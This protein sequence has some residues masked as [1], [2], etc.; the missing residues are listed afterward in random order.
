[1][2][3]RLLLFYKNQEKTES[4]KNKS[5]TDLYRFGKEDRINSFKK[6]NLNNEKLVPLLLLSISFIVGSISIFCK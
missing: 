6:I 1:M 4:N 3:S 5:H 2:F